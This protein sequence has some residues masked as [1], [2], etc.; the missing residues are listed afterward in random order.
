MP[1]HTKNL[2]RAMLVFAQLSP[3]AREFSFG[4]SASIQV[5]A[6]CASSPNSMAH[7]NDVRALPIRRTGRI[8][9]GSQCASFRSRWQ[10]VPIRKQIRIRN[11]PAMRRSVGMATARTLNAVLSVRCWANQVQRGSTRRFLI[12]LLLLIRLARRRCASFVYTFKFYCACGSICKLLHEAAGTAPQS[13]LS[14]RMVQ[15]G[16]QRTSCAS[17]LGAVFDPIINASAKEAVLGL[18]RGRVVGQ[19]SIMNLLH[20]SRAFG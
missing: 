7:T 15:N 14:Q 8:A 16:P 18:R 9:A 5:T 17:S 19:S 4:G 3:P 12:K 11:E 6:D 13:P 20:E 10:C 1:Q 2:S